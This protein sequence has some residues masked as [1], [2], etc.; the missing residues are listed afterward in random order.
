[1]KN[2][3]CLFI[4]TL[5]TLSASAIVLPSQ[6]SDG[7]VLQ[8]NS[9]VKI[10][11]WGTP[12]EK[13]EITP[14]WANQTYTVITPNTARWEIVIPTSK[15]GG[16]FTLKFKGYTEV[17][18][19]DILI[20]EVWLCSGQS[21]MEMTAAWGIDNG[22]AE[23][24]KAQYPTIRF[25][26]VAKCTADS[27]QNTVNGQWQSCSPEVMR[28]SSAVAYFF[29]QRLQSQFPNVPIGLIVSA[30]GG[31]PAEVW[32]PETTIASN[33]V[34]VQAAAKLQPN[35]YG[36]VLPGKTYNAMIHGLAEYKLSGMLW[37][38]G[39]SNVGSTVYDQTLE[40]LV[41][42]WRTQWKQDFPFYYVQIAQYGT[43]TQTDFSNPILRDSQRKAL[44]IPNSQMV[45]ITDLATADD[46]HPKNKK[47]VGVRLA[48][49][50][51][52]YQFKT[53]I[54]EVN[55]PLIATK[56]ILPSAIQLIFDHGDGLY[57]KNPNDTQFEIAGADGVYYPAKA[58]IKGATILL[59]SNQVKAPQRVRFAWHTAHTPQLFNKAQLPASVFCLE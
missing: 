41:Q 38:Q 35:E 50:A 14:E 33:P 7:M 48:N 26:T 32:I 37:Y 5:Y 53:L 36:P 18:L 45:V 3:I 16:P 25:F 30:W 1:M 6:F 59:K 11:G 58:Q 20:G 47:T 42:S 51:L 44:R 31:T 13:I 4:F 34:L 12:K 15:E 54:E 10:W 40:A 17:T 56:T 29:A 8:R 46:I 49:C 24:A 21:N 23:V 19:H 2:K 27:P 9:D 52:K 22:E 39:E 28:Y 43:P 55:G 57:F